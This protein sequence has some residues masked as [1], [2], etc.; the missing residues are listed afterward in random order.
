LIVLDTHVF[1]WWLSK[2]A[3]LPSAVRRRIEKHRKS[4]SIIVSTISFW[5]VAMLTQKGRLSLKFDLHTWIDKV[6]SLSF[7]KYISPDRS[8]FVDS[9][10]LPSPFHP[11]P[12]DRV[13][14]AT[15]RQCGANLVTK[16]SKILGYP[17]V[18][19]FW[20]D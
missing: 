19:A 6:A 1:L 17:H 7:I 10:Y 8:I 5:E 4:R 3:L 20:K 16:D 14:V 15:A 13:I 11:D 18:Q 2:D 12:A 9:V